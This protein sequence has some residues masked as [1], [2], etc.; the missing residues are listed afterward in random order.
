MEI[1]IILTSALKTPVIE[2]KTLSYNIAESIAKTL[3]KSIA[4][5]GNATL[6]VS[7][8]N[9]PLEIFHCLSNMPIPWSK[10]EIILGDDRLLDPTNVDSNEKLILENLMINKASKASYV[11]LIDPEL[12]PSDLTYPFD[13]VLLGMGLDGHF[14]SLFPELLVNEALFDINASQDFYLSDIPLGDPSYQRITMTLSML[15][16]T[17]RCILLVSSTAKRMVLDRAKED[18]SLPVY[19]LLNQ[20]KLTIEFSD[21]NF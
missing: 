11:S 19:H 18:N 10:I 8:G 20:N 9:S 1:L 4:R 2:V 21:I 7:G 14:A 16:N 6:V 13:V 12:L 15:L 5:R 3:E 17:Q